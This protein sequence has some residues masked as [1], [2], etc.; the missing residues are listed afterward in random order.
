MPPPSLTTPRLALPY[1]AETD[2][3]ADPP[4]DFLA[5]ATAL[6]GMVAPWSHGSGLGPRPPF[7]LAGRRYYNDTT[8]I[9]YLDIGTAWVTAPVTIADNQV[10]N[11]MIATDAVDART[12]APGSVGTSE[13]ADLGIQTGDIGDGMV[14]GAKIGSDVKPSL[15]AGAATEA[16]RAIG[17]TGSTVVAGNDARLTDTRAPT[18]GSVTNAS[19]AVA[20][21][22]AYSKLALTASIINADIAAAAAI[23]YSKLALTNSIVNGD[24]AA[25]AAIA[26][27]KLNLSNSIVHGD[28]AAAN[29]DGVAATPSMR[30]LGTG[31]QQAAAGNDARIVGDMNRYFV[32]ARFT[33]TT[34]AAAAIGTYLAGNGQTG[35]TDFFNREG[36]FLDPADLTPAIAGMTAKYRISSYIQTNSVGMGGTGTVLARLEALND[37][38]G[39]GGGSGFN[40]AGSGGVL[41]VL[42]TG[43]AA[44]TSTNDK[45][46]DTNA[47]AAGKYGLSLVLGVAALPAGC[48]LSAII[49]LQA[50]YV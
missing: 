24:I 32:I 7:G 30:T 27:S 47:P 11:A 43:L 15:G 26:Y 5:L 48:Q 1:P 39:T 25:A 38:F 20:A 6:D 10:V 42:K 41:G 49:E 28:V 16:L 50:R 23:A 46:A 45:G 31:A 29:K 19:V 4:R 35:S 34:A 2:A 12:I 13:L 3:P 14:T 37:S 18:A 8:G 36:F 22:I 33:V 44:N 21:A 17:A 9:E 40:A